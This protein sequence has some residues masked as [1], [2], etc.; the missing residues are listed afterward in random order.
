MVLDCGKVRNKNRV[1][2]KKGNKEVKEAMVETAPWYVRMLK[3]HG[4][5]YIRMCGG[6]IIAP[7]VV[8]SGKIFTTKL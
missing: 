6:T 7:N 4:D 5:T 2:H 8:I 1:I 3:L